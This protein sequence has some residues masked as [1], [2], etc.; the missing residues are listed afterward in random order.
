[1]TT[2]NKRSVREKEGI[3]IA[4]PFSLSAGVVHY[5]VANAI[6]RPETDQ[7]AGACKNFFSVQSWIDVSSPQYGI[8]L[9]TPDVPLFEIG[10]ITAESPWMTKARS[11][12]TIYSYVMNNYW[13][14]NYKADQEG[15]VT[16]RYFL[17]PHAKYQPGAAAKFG[18]ECRAQLIAVAGDPSH[19]AVASLF[20][21]EPKNILVTS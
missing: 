1:M 18:R 16:L 9:A 4:F 19:P 6:V 8:T 20:Y 10:E 15:V 13:H 11:S 2:I 3:H 21:V 12:S 5:D 17:M 7:L 14:T